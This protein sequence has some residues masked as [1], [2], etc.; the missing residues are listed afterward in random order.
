MHVVETPKQKKIKKKKAKIPGM[1]KPPPNSF[2][3]YLQERK[4]EIQKG[5][6]GMSIAAVTSVAS[7][8]W[9]E[10]SDSQKQIYKD[11]Y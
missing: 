8:E 2:V 6:T 5:S 1:P 9:K 11:Q 10:L 4:H 7:K 3:L